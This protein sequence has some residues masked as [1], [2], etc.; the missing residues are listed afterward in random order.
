MYF[1]VHLNQKSM[2]KNC[3]F[4]RRKKSIKSTHWHWC[5]FICSCS[6]NR[7]ELIKGKD[8]KGE[9]LIKN[10]WIANWA[11]EGEPEWWFN[12]TDFGLFLIQWIPDYIA[13]VHKMSS[14]KFSLKCMTAVM[15]HHWS[16]QKESCLDVRS[17]KGLNTI[18]ENISKYHCS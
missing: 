14:L 16:A 2:K 10:K 8:N 6:N 18:Y 12:V 5:S 7:G 3:G 4:L 17:F 11:I 9:K 13:R 1:V 15:L